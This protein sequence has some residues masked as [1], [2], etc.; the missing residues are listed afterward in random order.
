MKLERF[1]SLLDLHGPDL[2]SWPEAE[3]PSARVL[4]S[5]SADARSIQE[6]ALF[7]EDALNSYSVA[8]PSASFEASL[9]DL[10][11]SAT[12]AVV[13]ESLLS[14]I[15]NIRVMTSAGMALASM[16]FGVFIGLSVMEPVILDDEADAFL[17]A[18][19]GSFDSEFWQEE[20]AG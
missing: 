4:L 15:L 17:S 7:M 2:S 12:R 10:A 19:A 11:P 16:V 14:R 18:A 6:D 1:E 5:E 20:D 9:L 3:Q 13:K 8:M